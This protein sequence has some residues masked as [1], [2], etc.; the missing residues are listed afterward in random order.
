MTNVYYDPEEFGLETVGTIELA[1]PD[2]SFDFGVVWYHPASE[3]FYFATDSGCSCP[4][5]F[6]DYAD[7]DSLGAPMTYRELSARLHTLQSDEW[8]RPS[9]P[10]PV[11]VSRVLDRAQRLAP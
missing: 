5:P 4:T 11:Q 7:L 9:E 6:D 10:V 8:Q 2:Y 1:E 3:R